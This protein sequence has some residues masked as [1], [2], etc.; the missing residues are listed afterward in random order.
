MR[1]IAAGI[2]IETRHFMDDEHQI[3]IGIDREFWPV[4]QRIANQR[5]IDKKWLASSGSEWDYLNIWIIGRLSSCPEGVD[6][7]DWIS[8]ATQEN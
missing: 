1:S 7:H 4:V 3:T 8:K 2:N 5:A 6:A